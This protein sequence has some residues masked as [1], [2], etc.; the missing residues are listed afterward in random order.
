MLVRPQKKLFKRFG[1]S[2]LYNLMMP[3]DKTEVQTT[4]GGG[5]AQHTYET[6]PRY[7]V[8]K[9][10]IGSFFSRE[11]FGLHPPTIAKVW[12]SIFNYETGQHRSSN[13]QNQSNLAPGLFSKVVFHCVRNKNIQ[14]YTKKFISNSF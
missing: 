2:A 9:K 8:I 6:F 3:F 11:K 5:N 14:F 10:S 1:I 12:F 7:Q 4:I 13:C